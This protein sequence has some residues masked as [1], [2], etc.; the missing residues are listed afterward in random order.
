MFHLTDTNKDG[1]LELGDFEGLAKGF[2]KARNLAPDAP[3]AKGLQSRYRATWDL[4]QEA[5]ADQDGEVTLQEFLDWYDKLMSRRDVFD[6]MIRLEAQHGLIQH[7]L[8]ELDQDGDGRIT[9]SEHKS[10]MAALG[11]SQHEVEESF[12][13][14]DV[15]GDGYLSY[16]EMLKAVTDFYY[17]DD[18]NAPGNWLM[19]PYGDIA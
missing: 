18:P 16:E 4:L 12:Q 15:D 7:G 19:G 9:L 11:L 10:G 14:L 6:Q 3:Q 1:C 5:D 8:L 2:V 13:R 17:S